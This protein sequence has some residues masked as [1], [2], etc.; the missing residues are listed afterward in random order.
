MHVEALDT[1]VNGKYQ[2]FIEHEMLD[3]IR[4][5]DEIKWTAANTFTP[6]SRT[7][8]PRIYQR[9][10]PPAEMADNCQFHWRCLKVTN[11]KAM[12]ILTDRHLNKKKTQYLQHR[13]SKEIVYTYLLMQSFCVLSRFV[14]ISKFR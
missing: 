1:L 14:Q 8:M 2:R 13:L 5:E 7:K 4:Q 11:Y 6:T 10:G 9:G 3:E 12:T